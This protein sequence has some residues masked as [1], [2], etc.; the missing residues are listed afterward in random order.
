MVASVIISHL[1]CLCIFTSNLICI[2]DILKSS[3]SRNIF[4]YMFCGNYRCIQAYLSRDKYIYITRC[5]F[6]RVQSWHPK[7]FWLQLHCYL[8]T[9]YT[10]NSAIPEGKVEKE[11]LIYC[12]ILLLLLSRFSRV[13]LCATPWTAAYQAFPS[14]GFY[15]QEHWSGL[16]FPSPQYCSTTLQTWKT[17]GYLLYSLYCSY[18]LHLYSWY[19]SQYECIKSVEKKQKHAH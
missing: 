10:W 18:V 1:D 12:T 11:G 16:P 17:K 2:S 7:I 15:R 4:V 3:K 9:W 14:M 19:Q 5:F 8:L 13:R 6:C